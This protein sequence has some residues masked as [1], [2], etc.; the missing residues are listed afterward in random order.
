MTFARGL[1]LNS[2]YSVCLYELVTQWLAAKK[3]LV[4][5]LEIFRGQLGLGVTDYKKMNDFKKRVLK[6]SG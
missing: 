6:F 4:F 3:T 1:I 5:D 2:V